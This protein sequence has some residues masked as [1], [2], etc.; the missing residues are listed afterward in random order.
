MHEIIMPA[1]LNSYFYDGS[2]PLL[3]IRGDIKI[4]H[5]KNIKIKLSINSREYYF[6]AAS[7][8]IHQGIKL[9]AND[10]GREIFVKP[11]FI[12]LKSK[13]I[14]SVAAVKTRID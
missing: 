12:M 6:Q 2:S 5:I 13:R 10:I 1:I 4:S 8:K 7:Q 11:R 14:W 3:I 9:L